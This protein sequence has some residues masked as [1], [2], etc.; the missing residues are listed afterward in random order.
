MKQFHHRDPLPNDHAEGHVSVASERRLGS[1]PGPERCVLSCARAS[2]TQ[3]LSPVYLAQPDIPLQV[4]TLWP[5][6]QS[7]DLHAGYKACSAPLAFLRCPCGVL[8]GRHF[9]PGQQP[10]LSS[11]PQTE[12]GQPSAQLEILSQPG[13]IRLDPQP[14]IHLPRAAVG[15]SGIICDA[16]RRQEGRDSHD[17]G[18]PATTY[19]R[20]R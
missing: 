8:P 4:L 10:I 3:T 5:I 20:H 7:K 1:I 17:G 12:D 16:T 11:C 9:N 15:H 6:H 2:K 19:H 13:E 14:T 18:Q